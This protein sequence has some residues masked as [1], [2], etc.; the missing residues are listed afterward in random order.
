MALLA[1]CASPVLLKFC[2]QLYDLNIRYR[3]L[4]GHAMG[5]QKR[6]IAAEHTAIME[7]AIEINADLASERLT[8]HYQQTGEFLSQLMGGKE[9]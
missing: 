7:A 5:Y 3:Y 4:A 6:D 9:G 2:N 1:N 8:S